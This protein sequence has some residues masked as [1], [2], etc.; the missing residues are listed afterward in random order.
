VY[1][2]DAV[3]TQFCNKQT[4]CDSRSARGQTA[5]TLTAL[6]SGG[7]DLFRVGY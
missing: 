3:P 5:G 2:L 6:L 4:I 1:P 7:Q